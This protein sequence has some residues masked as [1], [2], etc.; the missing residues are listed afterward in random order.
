MAGTWQVVRIDCI[1]FGR[2][3]IR[4]RLGF[5]FRELA[6]QSCCAVSQQLALKVSLLFLHLLC[7]YM[8]WQPLVMKR[9]KK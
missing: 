8:H 6:F 5:F 1:H 4:F 9:A 3:F 2:F 7:T